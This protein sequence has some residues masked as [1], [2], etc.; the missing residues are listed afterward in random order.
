MLEGDWWREVVSNS[1]SQSEREDVQGRQDVAS[2]AEKVCC[3]CI[4]NISFKLPYLGWRSSD[5]GDLDES[6]S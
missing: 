2:D 5:E 3:K 6:E 4:S 1:E